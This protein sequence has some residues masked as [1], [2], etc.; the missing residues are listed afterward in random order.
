[1]YMDRDGGF[2]MKRT[3]VMLPLD[4]KI[5]AEKEA[6]KLGLSLG[7]LIR[8]SLANHLTQSR[9]GSDRDPF[10]AD[11]EVFRGYAPADLAENHDLYLYGEE[12]DLH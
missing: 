7:E 12:N 2:F 6:Y 10:F 4:L 9:E 5:K 11:N 3:T 1:M 8:I